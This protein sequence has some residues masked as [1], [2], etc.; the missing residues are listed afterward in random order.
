[1]WLRPDSFGSKL[2][3]ILWKTHALYEVEGPLVVPTCLGALFDGAV[4]HFSGHLSV[5]LDLV[6]GRSTPNGQFFS[7]FN[8]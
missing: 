2:E 6:A 7:A 1:M 5:W 3:K 4:L 8:K